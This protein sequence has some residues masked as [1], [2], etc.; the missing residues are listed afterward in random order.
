MIPLFDKPQDRPTSFE[1]LVGWNGEWKCLVN[2]DEKPLQLD[3]M[4]SLDPSEERMVTVRRGD[5]LGEIAA[6]HGYSVQELAAFNHI[7]DPD[8]IQE[9][10]QIRFP[11]HSYAVPEYLVQEQETPTSCVV[12]LSFVDVILKPLANLKVSIARSSGEIV[13]TV[14][15]EAGQIADYI[16]DVSEEIKISVIQAAGKIKEIATYTPTV[17]TTSE[18]TLISPKVKISGTSSRI[19]GQKGGVTTDKHPMNSIV[20]GRDQNGMAV[21]VMTH[22]CLDKK[23]IYDLNLHY[24]LEYFDVIVGAA[25][26][27][28]LLPQVVAALIDTESGKKPGSQHW[29][30]NSQN[31]RGSAS[32]LT[33]FITGTWMSETM[34]R[35]SW[36][37]EKAL[38]LG[39]VASKTRNPGVTEQLLYPAVRIY[40][41]DM[42]NMYD[43]AWFTEKDLNREVRKPTSISQGDNHYTTWLAFRCDPEYSVNAAVDYALYNLSVLRKKGINVDS[44]NKADQAKVIYM[45]H[46]LGPGNAYKFIREEIV[47]EVAYRLL[48]WQIGKDQA[49]YWVGKEQ[50]DKIKAHRGWLFEFIDRHIRPGDFY[51]PYLSHSEI[52]P[53]P[54]K[55]KLILNGL[56]K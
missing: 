55:L 2:T 10:Q 54:R 11:E 26:R 7:A 3:T 27:S 13:D 42:F 37:N 45:A 25:E 8:K 18:I 9:G 30:A 1:R 48:V 52:L 49:Q 51:C 12:R 14:T 22:T 4:V 33:Q 47:P 56:K 24:N 19:N 36:L 29:L 50:G 34:R 35:G 6:Q 53:K 39:F 46:Q 41:E 28:G 32:G 44:L 43:N 15:N 21:T 16:S 23:N 31:P 40:K 20:T 5:T 17:G 38:M